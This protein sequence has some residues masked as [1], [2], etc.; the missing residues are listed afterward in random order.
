M[1]KHRWMLRC[2]V[3]WVRGVTGTLTTRIRILV[4]G[5]WSRGERG[6]SHSM[7]SWIVFLVIGRTA[8]P[9]YGDS[10]IAAPVQSAEAGGSLQEI[11]VTARRREEPAGG[12]GICY[13][14]YGSK[15]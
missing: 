2:S 15:P 13:G 9:A 4:L 10:D 1:W 14:L 6:A 7:E 3:D 5:R 11:V 8:I 12:P